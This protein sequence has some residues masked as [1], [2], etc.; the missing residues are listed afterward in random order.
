MS[1]GSLA[2]TGTGIFTRWTALAG[3]ALI[4]VGVLMF[5]AVDAPRRVAYGANLL[6]QR[7]GDAAGVSG[8]GPGRKKVATILEAFRRP[9]RPGQDRP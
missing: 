3:A 4:L 8:N 2:F 7:V 1:S 9:A 5:F 6:F